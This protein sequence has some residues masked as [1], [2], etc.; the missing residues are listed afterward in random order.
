[1]FLVG[2]SV[3]PCLIGAHPSLTD[4]DA[5]DLKFHTDFRS[6]Y[7]TILQGWLKVAPEQVLG[8]AYPLL[9]LFRA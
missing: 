8:Q 3:R 2:E 5:G 6:V 1:M 9:E 7:A 4:L